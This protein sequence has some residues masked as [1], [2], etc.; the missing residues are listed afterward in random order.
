MKRIFVNLKRFEV[1]RN[2]G[3]VCPISDPGLWIA[4]VIDQGVSGGLGEL[5]GVTLTY[6]LPEGLV[7]SAQRRLAD[8]DERR[9]AGINLGCQGVFFEDIAPGGNFGAFTTSLPATAAR[10]LGCSWSIIG[11]SEERKAKTAV[12]KRF[13]PELDGDEERMS[14]ARQAVSA[15]IHDEVVCALKA[16]LDVLL[17]VGET[18]D[19]RGGGEL[20][21]AT[22]AHRS[23]P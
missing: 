15:I 10:Q 11:H 23:G 9:I 14:R 20:P 21:G 3:G 16:G 13:A 17:C 19:E 1:P 18:A 7:L 12:I 4:W 2:L 22:A 6:L 8:Y 5:P